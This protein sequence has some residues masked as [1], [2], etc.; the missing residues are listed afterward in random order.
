MGGE[1]KKVDLNIN[2]QDP[3]RTGDRPTQQ[4]ALWEDFD[5]NRLEAIKKNL[6]ERFVVPPFSVLDTRQGYWQEGKR[7][8]LELGIKSEVGRD[9]NVLFSEGGQSRLNEML[10]ERGHTAGTFIGVSVFDPV[11]CE[12]MYKWFCPKGGTVLDPFAGGSVRGVV[13]EYLGYKYTGIELRPEQI[14]SNQEQAKA[15]N[16]APLWMVGDSEEVLGGLAKQYDFIFSC[17]PYF[18]LE[19]YSDLP[20]ELSAMKKYEDFIVKYNRIIKK[21]VAKLQPNR[22]ACF[23]VSNI[24]NPKTGYFYNLVA[25]TQDAFAAAGAWLYNEA[26]LINPA[27]TL[28]IRVSRQFPISRKLGKSHQNVLIFFNGNPQQIKKDFKEAE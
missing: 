23:V 18:N 25:D 26:V 24:R 5:K 8:W 17:P 2:E 13:A 12:L 4:Q 10:A 15:I 1:E 22:F 11:V 28:P 19:V 3:E 7:L 6:E 14:K 16:L 9:E 21:L 20:G 27:G